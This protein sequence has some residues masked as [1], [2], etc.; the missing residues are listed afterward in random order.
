MTK[1]RFLQIIRSY[2]AVE[3]P[4]TYWYPLNRIHV[5]VPFVAYD[6]DK[7]YKEHQIDQIDHVLKDCSIDRVTFIQNQDHRTMSEVLS[8][9]N[10]IYEKD[11]GGACFIW[12]VESYYYDDTKQWLIYVSHEGTI[13]FT[14]EAIVNAAKKRMDCK[15]LYQ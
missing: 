4:F 1:E 13:T 7:I 11:D 3:L 10:R 6:L 12:D 14:G 2:C 15:Y 9:R 5:D 8:L